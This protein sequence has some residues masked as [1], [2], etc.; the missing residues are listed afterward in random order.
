MTR[1]EIEEK[2]EKEKKENLVIEIIYNNKNYIQAIKPIKKGFEYIY[3]EIKDNELKP[4]IDNDLLKMFKEKY[5]HRLS[6]II[7]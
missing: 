5:E 4:I 2:L 6:N 3:Y 1:T 7:Y